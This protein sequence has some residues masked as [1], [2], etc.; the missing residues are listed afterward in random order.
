MQER[1]DANWAGSWGRSATAY[2]DRDG[3]IVRAID[4]AKYGA[5][6]QGDVA[7]PNVKIPTIAAAV[8][9]QHEVGTGGSSTTAEESPVRPSET[10]TVC[11]S[12]VP[13]GAYHFGHTGVDPDVCVTER[14]KAPVGRP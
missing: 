9:Q 13:R 6:R 10:R 5:W 2:V 11:P 14:H 4:P 1:N 3:T 12:G 7:H 8:A